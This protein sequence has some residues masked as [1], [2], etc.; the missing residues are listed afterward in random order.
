MKWRQ[1]WS[2]AI[3]ASLAGGG[4]TYWLARRPKAT[5]SIA[6]D[7]GYMLIPGTSVVAPGDVAEN[8]DMQRLIDESNAVI[9]A[10][11]GYPS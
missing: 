5:T 7:Q 8:P 9:A 4:L 6:F 2:Y 11:G 1:W 10:T 3:A